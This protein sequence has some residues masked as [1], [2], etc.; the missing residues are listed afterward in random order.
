[1]KLVH[2]P[3]NVVFQ[4]CVVSSV[5]APVMQPLFSRALRIRILCGGAR[6]LAGTVSGCCAFSFGCRISIE[7]LSMSIP[8]DC[9][10]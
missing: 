4:R 3:V 1:M 8:C 5:F 10:G 2:S 9:L 7:S 6:I